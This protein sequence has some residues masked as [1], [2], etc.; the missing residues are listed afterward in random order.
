MMLQLTGGAQRTIARESRDEH[1]IRV[2]TTPYCIPP[3]PIITKS[4]SM[5]LHQLVADP[6]WF[7]VH[8]GTSGKARDPSPLPKPLFPS[9]SNC[10]H[11]PSSCFPSDFSSSVLQTLIFSIVFVPAF[12]IIII[13][14]IPPGC[15]KVALP[16]LL[17]L[18][19]LVVFVYMRY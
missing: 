12:I 14:I 1:T 8:Y 18:I 2:S 17:D 16:W 10:P 3:R 11:F 7:L 19:I 5:E 15:F 4:S 9:H 6:L 13:I